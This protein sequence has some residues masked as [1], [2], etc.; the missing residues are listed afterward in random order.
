MV[1]GLQVVDAGADRGDHAG[2]FV[3]EYHRGRH[4]PSSGGDVQVG[5]ADA[6]GG[7]LDSYLTRTGCGEVDVL[8]ADGSVAVEDGGLDARRLAGGFGCRCRHC[9]PFC[10]SGRHRHV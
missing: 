4:V 1:A 5:V 9:V 10:A 8:D 6:G 3:P 2:P 7:D